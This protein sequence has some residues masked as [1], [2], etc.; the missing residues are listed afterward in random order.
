MLRALQLLAALFAT[1]SL[2]VF[3]SVLLLVFR[4]V[5]PDFARLEAYPQQATAVGLMLAYGLMFTAVYGLAAALLWRRTRW[6]LA[7]LL[8]IVAC[9]GFP[10]G[11]V[12]GLAALVLLTR[13][14]VRAQFR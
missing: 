9:F 13:P 5:V 8:A 6:N 10:V 2:L 7:I 14:A 11:P 12:L 4:Y 3:A 1:A